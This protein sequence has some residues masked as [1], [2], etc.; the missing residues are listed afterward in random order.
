MP[1]AATILRGRTLR[2]LPGRAGMLVAGELVATLCYALT[3]K[4]GLGLGPLFVLQVGVAKLAGIAIGTSVIVVGFALVGLSM[5]MRSWPGP[6]T[7][8]LPILGGLSLDAMLPHLPAL[9]GWPLQL[10]T[11]VVA[12]WVM[13]LGGALVIRASV[14]VDAY[15][16][17]MM[18][19]HRI[20]GR[21]LGPIR[22]AMEATALAAGWLLGGPVGVGTVVTGLLIGPGLQFWM[23]VLGAPARA[24]RPPAPAREPNRSPPGHGLTRI[25]WVA[26]PRHG[27]DDERSWRHTG[28][29]YPGGPRRRPPTHRRCTPTEEPTDGHPPHHRTDRHRRE[30]AGRPTGPDRRPGPTDRRDDHPGQMVAEPDPPPGR[31]RRPPRCT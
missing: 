3:I 19:L 7:L 4:A 25:S 5:S 20:V 2:S 28:L 30:P 24:D 17:V 6:G 15:D 10:A 29:R 26:L 16:A 18:G 23:R 9:H 21:P 22:L 11:V 31:H 13:A 8:I 12:T 27:P 1:A 14:G